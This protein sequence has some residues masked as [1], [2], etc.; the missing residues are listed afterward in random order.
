MLLKNMDFPNV[1]FENMLIIV[2]V[3]GILEC[4]Y[5]YN[6][7]F[8]PDIFICEEAPYL[9]EFKRK[10]SDSK[11]AIDSYKATWRKL[12]KYVKTLGKKEEAD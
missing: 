9:Y 6:A 1:L 12:T 7:N 3:I 5:G 8:S 11:Y 2:G 10:H 4:Q